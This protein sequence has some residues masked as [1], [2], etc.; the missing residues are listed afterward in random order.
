MRC[1]VALECI[2][3]DLFVNK[4]R[5]RVWPHNH[6]V[7]HG[8]CKGRLPKRLVCVLGHGTIDNIICRVVTYDR[9]SSTT[10]Q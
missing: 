7:K 5:L 10:L 2:D 8:R 6:E 9:F 1:G 4:C 3:D